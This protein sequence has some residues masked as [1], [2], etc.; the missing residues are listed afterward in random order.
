MLSCLIE[1]T[2]PHVICAFFLCTGVPAYGKFQLLSDNDDH[3]A[4]VSCQARTEKGV[5]QFEIVLTSDVTIGAGQFEFSF[6][7]GVLSFDQLSAGEMLDSALFDSNVVTSGRLKVAFVSNEASKS[8]GAL[9]RVQMK[10][11]SE[12]PGND[13]FQVDKVRLWK[14]EDSSEVVPEVLRDV[15][16]NIPEPSAGKTNTGSARQE[17]ASADENVEAKPE[18]TLPGWVFVVGGAGAV[19]ILFLTVL[20]LRRKS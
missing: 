14:A 15:S 6:D 9:L 3:A 12:A 13:C 17:S 10:V 16:W 7:P 1:I 11:L 18:S 4:A 5:I 2:V 8:S 20:L 19:T